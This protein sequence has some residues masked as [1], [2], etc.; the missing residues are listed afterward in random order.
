M[1]EEVLDWDAWVAPPVP[2]REGT[3]LAALVYGGRMAPLPLDVSG[4]EEEERD[5]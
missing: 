4:E 3:I 2:R 5:S 1:P